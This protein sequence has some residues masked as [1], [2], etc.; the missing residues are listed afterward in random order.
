MDPFYFFKVI[1]FTTSE[2]LDFE[3]VAKINSS[4]KVLEDWKTW[5]LLQ[6]LSLTTHDLD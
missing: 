6:G 4:S 3:S 2:S 1:S 5:D